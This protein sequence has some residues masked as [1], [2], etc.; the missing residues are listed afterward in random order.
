MY[1]LIY[2]SKHK[3]TLQQI[4]SHTHTHVQTHKHTQTH[5]HKH[6]HTH[7]LASSPALDD[8]H[9]PSLHFSLSPINLNLFRLRYFEHKHTMGYARR[10]IPEAL[11]LGTYCTATSVGFLFCLLKKKIAFII[12]RKEI[13]QQFCLELSRC[14]LLCSPK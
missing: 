8:F 13:M 14:S 5:T 9:S 12:A 10:H 2:T 3:D 1:M 7:N 6:T 4:I 11:I